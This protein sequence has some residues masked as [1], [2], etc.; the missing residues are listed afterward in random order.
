MGTLV[1]VEAIVQPEQLENF[2]AM[3][4][5]GFA[6][7]RSFDGCNEISGYL[8][9]D[10]KTFLAIERWDSKEHYERYLAWRTETGVMDA[11]GN[12]LEAPLKIRF[13][14]AADV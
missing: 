1:Q 4:R 7:T 9:E 12:L 8:C 14:K 11:L 13:F 5:K 10:G 6:D 2:I 3:C